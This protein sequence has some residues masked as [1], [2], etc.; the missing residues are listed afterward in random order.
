MF[1]YSFPALPSR[2]F[3]L[4]LCLLPAQFLWADF[5]FCT[6]YYVDPS[7]SDT[8]PGTQAAPWRTISKATNSLVA[9]DVVFIGSG[10]YPERLIP[11]NSGSSGLYIT[12]T[13][14]DGAVAVLDGSTITLPSYD[15]GIIQIENKSHIKISGLQIHNAGP[16]LNNCG[17]YIENSDNIIIE[18]NTTY[19]TVSSGIGVWDSTSVIIDG[20]EVE[21]ACNDGEQ[22]CIT[23]A[24]TS[25]FEVKNNH[26][27]HNGPGTNG[28]EG[29]DAKD[30]SSNGQIY[31]NHVH[32][33]SRLGIYVDAWDKHTYDIEIYRNRVHGCQN[34]GITIAS[35]MGGLL[36]RIS[37]VNNIIHE[38]LNNGISITPNG[39]VAQ[40]P[41]SKIY[42]INNTLYNNGDGSVPNPWGGGIAVDNP[43][44][45][46]LVIR[47]NIFS[48]NLL[49]QILLEVSVN[50]LSVDHNLIDGYRGYDGETKGSSFVEGNPLFLNAANG[51]FHL[52]SASPAIDNG[53]SLQ[54]P[55]EDF[56]SIQ[57]PQGS[58]FDIGAFEYIFQAGQAGT[59]FPGILMLLL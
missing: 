48:R 23:V 17:I 12:Y 47:N 18:K 54:A 11:L 29:I 21:L 14:Q 37:I 27:H 32:D 57:R 52:G 45:D 5:V 20:N 31:G 28:G 6:S 59:V 44:I 2:L 13:I 55:N 40:P 39:D 15:S 34:D 43:N 56:D 49:F 50:G 51:D 33:L 9:G 24:A 41:M 46:T 8:N 10:T 16:N 26:V 42:V 58:G 19:N 3:L 30:G 1:S 4:F 53:S 38:N 25:G 36:E 35:E 22:E 7:G